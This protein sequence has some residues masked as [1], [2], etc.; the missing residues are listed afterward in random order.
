MYD[1]EKYESKLVK[2][3]SYRG[4]YGIKV[5]GSYDGIPTYV[6]SPEKEGM[7]GPLPLA[8]IGIRDEEYIWINTDL[9]EYPMPFED[10]NI[11]IEL[12]GIYKKGEVNRRLLT[13]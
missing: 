13:T 5:M 11:M 9:E 10:I 8:F 4:E 6:F 2:L 12:K 1:S 3:D 7:K